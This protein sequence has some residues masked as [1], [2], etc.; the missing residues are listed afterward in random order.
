MLCM[1][2]EI[3]IILS[4]TGCIALYK[5]WRMVYADLAY[6]ISM[7]KSNDESEKN[8]IIEAFENNEVILQEI[9]S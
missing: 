3:V 2:L 1:F 8:R 9:E 6:A 4:I 5:A 7:L